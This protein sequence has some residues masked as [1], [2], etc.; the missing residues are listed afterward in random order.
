MRFCILALAL[1]ACGG[2]DGTST[3]SQCN[4]LGGQGCLLPWPSMAYYDGSHISIPKT[5][6]PTNVDGITVDSA[7]FA[8]WD[9]FSPTGPMLAEFP[10]GV[11]G[12]NL[13]SF[14][15]PDESLAA[16]SP[17]VL[18]DV[19][20]GERTP[21][22]AE[23]DQNTTDPTKRA[24][25]I[26]PLARLHEKSHYAVALRNTLKDKDGM[27]LPVSPE[28]AALRDG[29]SL[30]HPLWKNLTAKSKAMF[31]AFAQAGVTK[32]EMVLAWDF[33]TASDS[34]LQSDLMH[35]RDVAIPAMG[36]NGA[37]L[38]FT[39]TAQPPIAGI[40][41][42]YVG[43]FKSPGF[44]SDGE[45]DDS[46]FVRGADGLPMLQGLRDA[47]FAALLPDATLCPTVPRP[48]VIFGHGL[49]GSAK[50]YLSDS[51]VQSIAKTYC[52]NI[53]AG[54]FIG[55]TNRQLSLAPLAVNDMNK[56][57]EIT[58][59]LGQSII[60]FIALETL[61]RG[62]MGTH[63]EFQQNGTSVI[64]TNKVFYVG[65]SLGG[66]MGNTFMAY[67]PN[68]TRGV[69]A[70]PG[71]DWS[72]LFERSNAW[73]LLMGAAQGAYPDPEVYQLNLAF[74]G[75]GMEPYDPITT[76]AHVLHDPLPGVPAKTILIWY[77]MG[78]CLVTNI[79][80]ELVART[81]GIDFLS[82][83]VKDVWHLTPKA[84]PLVSGINVFNDHPMPLPPETNVPP[85]QDNG[86]HSGINRKPAA[87][88][89]VEKFL[90]EDTIVQTCGQGSDGSG[91][92]APC[93][94]ATGAC[95]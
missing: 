50:D 41:A 17:I 89:S 82:P 75:M 43:T 13:P 19:D 91:A 58:E 67:D 83:N 15:N 84:G 11:S 77:T 76:A 8:R 68:I 16:D 74:L 49:F 3:P 69:L 27:P 1:V 39:A 57:N 25:I 65:G 56:G 20:T 55:L 7:I 9:G 35:M 78:D 90:L 63:P 60:D 72:L 81:M 52:F 71:G 93:D 51:F 28:F 54:D 21:F 22:F 4:P 42:S 2:D 14:K 88:R 47:Q 40:A 6:M 45:N 94:C 12:D 30:S 85:S 38:T 10:N 66:I 29:K 80:T 32:D 86:T 37:N 53:I 70:V 73:H 62:P 34:F 5:A 18:L 23:I 79:S 44:L 59:K 26:R 36:T 92:S 95:N 64:D 87:L 31:D 24:L 48:T 46:I 33:Q 61:T